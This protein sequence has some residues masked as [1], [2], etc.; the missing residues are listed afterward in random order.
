MQTDVES[1]NGAYRARGRLLCH[2][3]SLLNAPIL[4][5]R[6]FELSAIL[7]LNRQSLTNETHGMYDKNKNMKYTRL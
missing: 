1:D 2:S 5:D 4:I 7:A 6:T 3:L